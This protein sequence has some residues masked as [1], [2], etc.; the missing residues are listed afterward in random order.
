[1]R[2]RQTFTWNVAFQPSLTETEQ[3]EELMGLKEDIKIMIFFLNE[4]EKKKE[5]KLKKKLIIK[6]TD[7]ETVA[8]H[9]KPWR[10]VVTVDGRVMAG[11]CVV[12][13]GRVERWA[14]TVLWY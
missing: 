6:V 1:M 8:G 7:S 10:W 3:M 11:I 13:S 9:A 14:G 2:K 4:E 5:K 12:C